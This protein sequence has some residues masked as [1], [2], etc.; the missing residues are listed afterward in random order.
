MVYRRVLFVFFLFWIKTYDVNAHAVY[1]SVC[2]IYEKGDNLFFSFRIFKDDV[3][4]ALNIYG[5]SSKITDEEKSKILNYVIKNFKFKINNTSKEFFVDRLVFE[6]S[7]Y[8][9]TVNVVLFTKKNNLSKT[10]YI[11]NTVLLDH[12]DSQMNVVG[13]NLG[14]QRKTLTFKKNLDEKW[15]EID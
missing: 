8:T 7:D 9:E 4:D 1:V 6:G 2:N 14:S 10:F 13:I 5:E 3:F 12:L 15:I 11:K